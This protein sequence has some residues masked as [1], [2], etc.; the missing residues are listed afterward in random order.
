MENDGVKLVVAIQNAAA[1]FASE[2]D[3]TPEDMITALCSV[4]VGM[5]MELSKDGREAQAML[6]M[7]KIINSMVLIQLSG[8]KDDESSFVQR[9]H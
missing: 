1:E 3:V 5:T 8:G 6:S 2:L 9:H 4:T 7:M